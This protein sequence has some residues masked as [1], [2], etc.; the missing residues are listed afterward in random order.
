MDMGVINST[1]TLYRSSLLRNIINMRESEQCSLATT[2]KKITL[3]DAPM[4][5]VDA[6]SKITLDSINKCWQRSTL[7]QPT[8]P[9]ADTEEDTDEDHIPL[10]EFIDPEDEVP[11]VRLIE[12]LPGSSGITDQE[13]AEWIA[14]EDR[15]LATSVTQMDDEIITSVVQDPAS[16]QDDSR[17]DEGP[18]AQ[19]EPVPS[20]GE[21]AE[22]LA[23]AI[24]WF[25]SSAECDP[26]S[27]FYI[28]LCN[29]R[30]PRNRTP[31]SNN[32]RSDTFS[33]YHTRPGLPLTLFL[34]F[35]FFL[36]TFAYIYKYF[37]YLRYIC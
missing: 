17:D 6:W 25:E 9:A 35:Y 8:K 2:L 36:C 22:H 5:A 3:K 28:E 30:P 15:E 16:T 13:V 18:A 32:I 37:Y 10:A 11:L 20:A 21:A 14:V 4:Q 34:Y 1:K 23:A 26:N 29:A 12:H 19:M 27:L 31:T 7:L 33:N 24:H